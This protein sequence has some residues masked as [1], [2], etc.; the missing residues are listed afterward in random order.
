MTSHNTMREAQGL[1][2]VCRKWVLFCSDAFQGS[3][4]PWVILAILDSM[5]EALVAGGEDVMHHPV[6]LNSSIESRGV[7]QDSLMGSSSLLGFYQGAG[8]S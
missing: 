6:I 5:P 1:Y 8:I 7:A 3:Q 2:S 4:H